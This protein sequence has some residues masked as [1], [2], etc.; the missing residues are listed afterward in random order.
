MRSFEHV[1]LI[2]HPHS[3][4]LFAETLQNIIV[5]SIKRSEKKVQNRCIRLLGKQ[6]QFDSH[7]V[8]RE[9]FRNGIS[10]AM[11]VLMDRPVQTVGELYFLYLTL[12]VTRWIKP[13]NRETLTA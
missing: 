8:S 4:S 12:A 1:H 13:P 5:D 6:S 2:G 3:R 7:L 9:I 10:A 11:T